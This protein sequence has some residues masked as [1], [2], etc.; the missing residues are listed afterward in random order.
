MAVRVSPAQLAPLGYHCCPGCR[1]HHLGP[2]FRVIVFTLS[3]KRGRFRT[4][5]VGCCT[6][7]GQPREAAAIA[8]EFH[9]SEP[10]RHVRFTIQQPVWALADRVLIRTVL[11]NLLGNAWKFT[12][13]QD[14]ASVEL[15]TEPSGDTRLCCYVR[16]NGVGLRPLIRPTSYSSRSSG[17]TP[18][19]R[20]LAPA[21]AWPASAGS[22]SAPAARCEPPVRSAKA[23]HSLSPSRPGTCSI[24]GKPRASGTQAVPWMC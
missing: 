4:S 14:S 20:S 23:P 10:Y 17:C 5:G 11:Q 12:S 21:L 16:D 6:D 7:R 9:A 19:N 3:N 15:G 24:R 2:T 8:P 13:G 18:R 1:A 22:S